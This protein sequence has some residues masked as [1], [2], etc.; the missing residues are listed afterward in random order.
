M[1]AAILSGSRRNWRSLT[2][3]VAMSASEIEVAI[4]V[5]LEGVTG[6]VRLEGVEFDAEAEVRLVDVE[7]IAELVPARG[8]ARQPRGE[9]E[10]DEAPLEL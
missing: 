9:E 10:V 5:A 2:R 1:R 4:V 7:L 3:I 6:A 8:G